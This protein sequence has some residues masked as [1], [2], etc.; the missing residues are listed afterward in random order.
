M[1][2]YK[3]MP[4]KGQNY[5]NTSRGIIYDM[6][7]VGKVFAYTTVAVTKDTPYQLSY[8]EFGRQASAI[9]TTGTSLM[10]GVATK[11]LPAGEYGE[12]IVEGETT[13]KTA[14]TSATKG[15]A[16][17]VAAGSVT[18]AGAVWGTGNNS[19]F[20]VFTADAPTGTTHTVYMVPR[21][22]TWS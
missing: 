4:I 16:I 14:S 1:Y 17:K 13:I 2:T 10:I 7:G 8:G 18:S 11:S 22:I 20:G 12:F 6:D 3:G 19:Y 21:E 15:H 5:K 9:G